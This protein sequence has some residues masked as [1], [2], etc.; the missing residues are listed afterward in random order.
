MSLPQLRDA[1]RRIAL[2]EIGTHEVGGNNRGPRVEEY[3]AAAGLPPG[4]P[5]CVAF[6]IWCYQRAASGLLVRS[7]L[8]RIGHAG[9]FF[10][11]I[12]ASHG[13]WVSDV[14]TVGAIACH[15]KDPSDPN[16]EGHASI[17]DEIE[18]VTLIDVSG[19]TNAQGSRAGNLV[20]PNR[21][22]RTYWNLGFIDVGRFGPEPLHLSA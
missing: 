4:Q 11:A 20:G 18:D 13:A 14:P 5:W 12:A 16:S 7:P 1:A 2:G 8:P 19:N 15:Q 22:P 21:R 10:R 3:L 17:I 9:H 6:V